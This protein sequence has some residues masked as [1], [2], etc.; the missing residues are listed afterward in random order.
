MTTKLSDRITWRVANLDCENEARTIEKRLSAFPGLSEL[1]VYPQTAKVSFIVGT[2][3]PELESIKETLS[4]LGFPI[5]HEGAAPV[6]PPVWRNNK[7]IVSAGSGV[8]LGVTYLLESIVLPP[9]L[10][11]TVLYGIGML[12]GGWYFFREAITD[13]VRERIVG[14][15]LLMMVAA[16]GAFLLGQH[17]QALIL[18][19]L[20]SISEALEGYT[21]DK[22][23]NAVRALMNLAPGMATVLRDSVEVDIPVEQLAVGDVFLLRSGQ[24]IPTDGVIVDGTSHVNEATLTG[25]SRPVLKTIDDPVF[26]GT[27]NVEGML[28]IKATRTTSD[29]TLSRIIKLVEDA[30]EKKA[31]SELM[32]RRFGR[33]Y[34]PGVLLAGLLLAAVPGLLTGDWSE[35]TAR[36]MVFIVSASPCALIIS[37][38]ITMVAA[39]GTGARMGI[40]LKG[41]NVLEQLAGVRALAFDKT[42]TLTVGKPKVTRVISVDGTSEDLL[43]EIA[44]SVERFS[45]HPLAEAIVNEGQLRGIIP[46]TVRDATSITGNGIF[47]RYRDLEVF[48]GKKE[49]VAASCETSI[50][51]IS[52][53]VSQSG[54]EEDSVVY[55]ATRAALLGAILIGDEVRPNAAETIK[56]LN[57]CGITHTAL[58]TGDHL[59]AAS[60]I[61]HLTGIREFHANLSPEDK[62]AVIANLQSTYGATAM[63]GDGVNDAPAL[64]SA[65]VGIA[66]GA[67]G[68]DVALETADVA[69]LAD[70]L[71]K[72]S[73]SLL[74][75][76]KA[77]RV[78]RQNLVLSM[79]VITALITASFFGATLPIAVVAHE[80]SEFIVILNGLR[81]LRD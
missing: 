65:T 41:G 9:S 68:S 71:S 80:A 25:E 3:A 48:I 57:R 22:T 51:A 77:R 30:Q 79:V 44:A 10:L 4:E 64:A 13:F 56:N 70:D 60:A 55:I 81:L 7:V 45:K 74:L 15:E 28:S 75:A 1:L 50:D 39:I 47:A 58:L 42:G 2:G 5:L 69:L 78:V 23:R 36:A 20:Y 54:H 16:I 21:V 35:W 61:A 26:A 43:I 37:I 40:L 73:Q 12:L 33:W 24:S 76:K 34:S 62:M 67:A 66:M 38:P 17:V 59:D 11:S 63:I 18:V 8:L 32:I 52:S 31:N 53:S 29:N 19:F 14:I 27:N 46:G 49:W 6:Y 72:I